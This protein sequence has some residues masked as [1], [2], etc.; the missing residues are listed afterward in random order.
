MRIKQNYEIT[1]MKIL[2]SIGE[3]VGNTWNT[4]DRNAHWILKI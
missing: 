4:L 3:I 2:N 1:A